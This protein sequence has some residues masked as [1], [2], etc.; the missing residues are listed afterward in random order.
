[1]LLIPLKINWRWIIGF[2]LTVTPRIILIKDIM[3]LINQI[4]LVIIGLRTKEIMNRGGILMMN[5]KNG[6]VD[7]IW[8]KLFLFSR[9]IAIIGPLENKKI[10]QI[11]I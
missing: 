9:M 3:L 1:M 4:T 8:I 6:I 10:Q 2:C 5:G 7:G 11:V